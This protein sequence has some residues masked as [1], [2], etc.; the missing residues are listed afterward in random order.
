MKL[1]LWQ[2]RYKIESR[3][4]VW[5][6]VVLVLVGLVSGLIGYWKSRNS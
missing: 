2:L 5:N 4:Q 3:I 1:T 6:L